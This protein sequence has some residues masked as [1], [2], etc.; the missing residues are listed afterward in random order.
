MIPTTKMVTYEGNITKDHFGRIIIDPCPS[1]EHHIR[2]AVTKPGDDRA[3]CRV[4]LEDLF[5]PFEGKKGKLH[6]VV[7]FEQEEG[8]KQS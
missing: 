4:L 2:Y 3:R 1:F 5:A 6:I 7:S 8:S